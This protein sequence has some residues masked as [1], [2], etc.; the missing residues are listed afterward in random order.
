MTWPS[1]DIPTTRSSD[2]S[3]DTPT[4]PRP[5][6]CRSH[7]EP[8]FA[9]LDDD[10]IE[11]FR[12]ELYTEI[13][14]P[15][16][17]TVGGRPRILNHRTNDDDLEVAL[18]LMKLAEA[19]RRVRNAEDRRA[20]AEAD[21]RAHTCQLCGRYDPTAVTGSY[22]AANQWCELCRDGQHRQEL[23]AHARPHRRRARLSP[24]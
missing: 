5:G 17:R 7:C 4:R 16:M 8:A 11:K 14:E 24:T 10:T 22:V 13:N 20:G 2:S 9:E 6:S 15:M 12:R 1:K 18:H 19:Q 3:R 21:R 23:D